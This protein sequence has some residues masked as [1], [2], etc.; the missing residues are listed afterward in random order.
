VTDAIRPALKQYVQQLK[1]V[2]WNKDALSTAL[3][4][5]LA[6]HQLK[7]PQLAMPLRLLITGQMQT[8]S[9]DAVIAL[10]DREVVIARLVK[11]L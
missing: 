6:A 5:V 9:I 8:P 7:M 3:K 1:T 2:A 4:A 11:H 10:F